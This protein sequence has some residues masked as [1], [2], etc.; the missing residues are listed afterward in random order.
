MLRLMYDDPEVD[1]GIVVTGTHLSPAFGSTYLEIEAAGLPVTHKVDILD[2]D[3]SALGM[4][5]AT[6]KGV[7]GVAEAL[8]IL[9]PDIVVLLGDRFEM[10]AAALAATLINIPIAHI[11]GGEATIGAVDEQLRNAMTK[12]SHLHFASTEAYRARIIQMGEAP[13]R[14]FNVG[15]PGVENALAEELIPIADLR[16]EFDLPGD[17]PFAVATFHPVT[18]ESESTDQQLEALLAA[19]ED[20]PALPVIWTKANADAGGRAINARLE[21]WTA[22][23]AGRSRLVSSLGQ[24]KYL[25]LAA[26]SSMVIG[27]SSSGIIEVPSLGVPTVNI[28]DRQL[29]RIR[30][31]SVIDCAP[32]SKAIGAALENA[33]TDTFQALA[34][35]CANPYQK[36][37]TASAICGHIK[38]ADKTTFRL[39]KFFDL[40]GR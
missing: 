25:S 1:L 30:G 13:E 40:P 16:A 2:D 37:G 17:T 15:A 38:S 7:Q 28:G 14:V 11:H 32:S 20:H 22:A 4:A 24:R 21:D 31:E 5:A 12:L 9:K 27:N 23:H 18:L 10:M 19:L 39:K 36:D 34:K 6:A 8:S 3:D 29:G 33:M 26:A 35:D